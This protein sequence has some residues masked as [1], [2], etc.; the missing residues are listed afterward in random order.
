[1]GSDR[2]RHSSYGLGFGSTEE[3][4]SMGGGHYMALNL[5]A[6]LEGV[7]GVTFSTGDQKFRHR[8]VGA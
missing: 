2:E 8:A 4:W 7:E 1:M 3:W 6:E 5:S